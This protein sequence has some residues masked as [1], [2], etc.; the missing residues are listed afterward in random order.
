MDVKA[1]IEIKNEEIDSEYTSYEQQIQ[2][3]PD[4]VA[5]LASSNNIK[6]EEPDEAAPMKLELREIK[7]ESMLGTEQ[8]NNV[9]KYEMSGRKLAFEGVKI[10]MTLKNVSSLSKKIEEKGS[11]VHFDSDEENFFGNLLM[12]KFP[13]VKLNK[14]TEEEIKVS[15][16][17]FNIYF[18]FF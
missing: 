18:K 12:S 11:K 4:D 6:I 15:F 13:S 2:G 9:I 14:L 17:H 3:L 7:N 8:V 10:F 16:R 1:E 5:D